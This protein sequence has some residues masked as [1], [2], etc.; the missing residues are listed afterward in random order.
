LLILVAAP[1]SLARAE[2]LTTPGYSERDTPADLNPRSRRPDMMIDVQAGS[3]NAQTGQGSAQS[4]SQGAS[5]G[6]SRRMTGRAGY[7]RR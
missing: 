1:A 6:L 5:S 3:P 2:V 4:S 7:P